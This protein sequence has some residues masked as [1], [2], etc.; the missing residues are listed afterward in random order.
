MSDLYKLQDPTKQYP[1]PKFK[2][3]PQSVPGLDKDMTPKADH[4]ETSYKG[5][6][7]LPKRKAL[8]TGGDSGIGRAAAIAFAREGADVVINYLPSEEADAKEVIALIEKEGRKAYAMPGDLS[9]EAFCRKLVKDAHKKL[10]GLDILACVAGKQHAVEK[11]KDV[12]TEQM[13]ATYRVNVF[14]L[15][16]LCQEALPLMPAGGSIITT[17]SIQAT[18]PSP[19]LLDYAPTKAA[20]LAFTRALARQVA[21]DGIRVNCVAPGPIWT[22]LQVSGGQPDKKIPEFGSETPMKRPGQP[23]ELAPLYVLLASQEASYVTGE[24]YGA[25]GGLEIS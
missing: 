5:N 15:F 17:A 25:T 16:W 20:I 22:P 11:I 19:S 10:G 1:Q 24:V 2:H 23:V 12:T 13:E 8:V 14:A 9:D 6:G 4:G 7:R 3:Q 21:E 18:H